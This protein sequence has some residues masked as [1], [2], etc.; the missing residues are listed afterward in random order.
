MIEE[1]KNNSINYEIIYP[2]FIS[3]KYEPINVYNNENFKYLFYKLKVF[4]KSKICTSKLSR[5]ETKHLKYLRDF[6]EKKTGINEIEILH[7]KTIIKKLINFIEEYKYYENYFKIKSPKQIY[8][9]CSY[10]REAIISA[11]QD[12]GIEVIELQHG[13]FT[14]YH[15]GY[16][17]PRV[18]IP[19]FPNKLMIFGE[20][21]RTNANL[22]INTEICLYGYPYLR[23]QL[24]KYKNIKNK[25]N[26]IIFVSQ[27]TIGKKLSEIALKFALDN[28]NIKVIYRL[29]PGEFLRWKTEYN[30]LYENRNLNNIEISDNNDKNLYEFLLESEYLIGVYSTVI[31][32]ALEIGIKIGILKLFGYESVE[33]LVEKNYIYQF[34]DNEKIEL[35][36]LDDLKKMNNG[37]IFMK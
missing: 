2:L 11:A 31:Y 20:Y 5:Y 23:F 37:Y 18:H 8:I 22:P 25:K 10:G 35:N 6:L 12:L 19:Y 36:K 26:Q 27:G 17:F 24:N 33:D 4:F 21:W 32:E 7:E 16:N 13:V 29:H 28:P 14:K 3:K 15:L 1:F 9:I 34:N 30:L